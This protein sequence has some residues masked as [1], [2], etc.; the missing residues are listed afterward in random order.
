MPREIK[1][2]FVGK[3]AACRRDRGVRPIRGR[4]RAR[5]RRQCQRDRSVSARARHVAQAHSPA[6]GAAAWRFSPRPGQVERVDGEARR[7]SSPAGVPAAAPVGATRGRSA[8]GCAASGRS[9]QPTQA[10]RTGPAAAVTA[11]NEDT[12]GTWTGAPRS[13]V[14]R[15]ASS[16]QDRGPAASCATKG[17]R[18]YSRPSSPFRKGGSVPTSC[19]SLYL[20]LAAG[21]SW[22][23]GRPPPAGRTKT[24]HSRSWPTRHDHQNRTPGFTSRGRLETRVVDAQCRRT[25]LDRVLIDTTQ[26]HGA[27]HRRGLRSASATFVRASM[28]SSR[29]T[30]PGECRSGGDTV[31]AEQTAI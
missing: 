12:K 17:M 25:A 3:R 30:S 24:A 9:D 20:S 27:V 23:G 15:D 22:R 19:T 18:V 4:L 8:P 21:S 16:T 5:Q 28:P 10:R 6:G 2:R 14:G 26:P 11:T 13:L 31:D 7:C 29:A 1:A